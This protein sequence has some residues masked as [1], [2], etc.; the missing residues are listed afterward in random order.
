[1]VLIALLIQIQAEGNVN[2]SSLTAKETELGINNCCASGTGYTPG[3]A[4]P[5]SGRSWEN[6]LV[7]QFVQLVGLRG[8]RPSY[9]QKQPRRWPLR[10]HRAYLILG[11]CRQEW[12]GVKPPPGHRWRCVSLCT[13]LP[14]KEKT[15]KQIAAGLSWQKVPEEAT[16]SYRVMKWLLMPEESLK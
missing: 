1:M 12:C 9:K 15:E 16:S 8:L 10:P 14:Q 11:P 5:M 6:Q 7:G 2:I 4:G 13:W 3:Q